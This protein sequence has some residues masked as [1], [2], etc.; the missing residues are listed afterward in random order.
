MKLMNSRNFI[1]IVY[2]AISL[3]KSSAIIKN[4][5]KLKGMDISKKN[6]LLHVK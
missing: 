3:S 6:A 5:Y 2:K 1:F 4:V